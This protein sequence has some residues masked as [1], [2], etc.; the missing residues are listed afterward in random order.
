VVR[1][2][3]PVDDQQYEETETISD[4]HL[5]RRLQRQH[6]KYGEGHSK[7][8]SEYAASHY[9]RLA[10]L[11]A[12]ASRMPV[13]LFQR[14][15][16][17]FATAS[18]HARATNNQA[19]RIP[20]KS[21][22]RPAKTDGKTELPKVAGKVAAADPE[23]WVSVCDFR[24]VAS[25]SLTEGLRML[26]QQAMNVALFHVFAA[27]TNGISNF[28][29]ATAIRRARTHCVFENCN[30]PGRIEGRLPRASDEF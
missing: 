21:S 2:P 20:G 16:T 17:R 30:P 25:E 3:R 1:T 7:Q 10:R 27:T 8:I 14:S 18:R 19:H 15:I 24:L 28:S 4:L 12:P 5:A 9:G 22:P 11:S 23:G 29:G 26:R 6:G 13:G